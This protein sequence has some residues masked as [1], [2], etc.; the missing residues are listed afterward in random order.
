MAAAA[1]SEGNSS[2]DE[3]VAEEKVFTGAVEDAAA[4]ESAVNE[5]E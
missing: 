3:S 1:E 4:E 2:I 5:Q